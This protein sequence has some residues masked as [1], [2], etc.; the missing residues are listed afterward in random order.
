[1][2]L[3]GSSVSSIKEMPIRHQMQLVYRVI[4]FYELTDEALI[5]IF[6]FPFK[7]TR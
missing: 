7:I 1:M 5:S 3:T 2:I 4:K 6:T